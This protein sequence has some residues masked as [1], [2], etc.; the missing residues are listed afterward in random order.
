MGKS[1]IVFPNK[2]AD[3]DYDVLKQWENPFDE[4]DSLINICL[5]K[6]AAPAIRHDITSTLKIG[7]IALE[8]FWKD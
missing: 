8:T 3:R 6:V 2:S 4:R 7:E 5:G 1:R